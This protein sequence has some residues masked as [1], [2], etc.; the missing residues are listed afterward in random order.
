[1]VG[2]FENKRLEERH[3]NTTYIKKKGH[4]ISLKSESV[5]FSNLNIYIDSLDGDDL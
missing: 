4:N 3:I 5:F 1:M 2:G